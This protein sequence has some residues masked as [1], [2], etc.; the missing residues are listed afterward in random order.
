M[1]KPLQ[2]ETGNDLKLDA[3]YEYDALDEQRKSERVFIEKLENC[4][5]VIL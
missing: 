5:H 2:N 3:Q 1:G 4:L